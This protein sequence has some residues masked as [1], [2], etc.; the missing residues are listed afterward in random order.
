MDIKYIDNK[1]SY[2]INYDWNAIMREY[3]KLKVPKEF[4]GAT[5]LPIEKATY[6]VILSPR[7]IG[8]TTGIL[9]LGMVMNS[10]Y[11]TVM[12]Y[13]RQTED[14]IKPSTALDLF[15]VII[16][17][18]DGDY[19]KKVT[20]GRYNSICYHWRAYYYCLVDDDGKI[21]ERSENYFCKVL[22]IDKAFNYKS[23]YN[24]PTGDIIIYDEFISNK[25]QP[26]EFTNF[27]D[28]LSTIIRG[29]KCAKIF[30]LANTISL[31]S[32]Y[33]KEMEIYTVIKNMKLGQS[34]YI[35][36]DNGT[37][38]FFA[39]MDTKQSQHRSDLNRLYFGFRNTRL[40][41]ITGSDTYAF[42][43]APHI[44]SHD[45]FDILYEGIVI[46]TDLGMYR[47]KLVNSESLGLC[48]Y[49]TPT[50]KIR[51]D[52]RVYTNEIRSSI[53]EYHGMKYDRIDK[54]LFEKLFREGRF[55]YDCNETQS[56]IRD[57]LRICYKNYR[58]I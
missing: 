9:L 32:P 14:M 43:I 12:Q 57:Y 29:R 53:Q 6:H 49:V 21:L 31:T 30:M 24:S 33:F 58:A 51:E 54:I 25:Y 45:K 23:A 22:S 18:R 44:P 2:G 37:K 52:D 17:Y 15:N 3:K 8:K 13:I 36:T 41:S 20:K 42:D 46:K 11:G 56:I 28:L 47:I 40:N 26:D 48:V 5:D 10:M 39:L 38:L 1:E 34:N 55:Y 7:R 50:T 4:L 27:M 16:E 35:T 19:I